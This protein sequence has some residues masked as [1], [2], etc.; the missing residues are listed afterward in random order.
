MLCKIKSAVLRPLGSLAEIALDT[1]RHSREDVKGCFGDE[2]A[3]ARVL[4]VLSR[5][6]ELVCG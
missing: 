5:V 4:D 1:V 6:Q 3:L 2:L